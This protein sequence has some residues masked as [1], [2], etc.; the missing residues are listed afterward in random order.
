MYWKFI[1]VHIN[2]VVFQHFATCYRL[3]QD[4]SQGVPSWCEQFLHT[5]L[6]DD[7]IQILPSTLENLAKQPLIVCP[8]EYCI[9]QLT[10]THH[11][12][13]SQEPVG[14]VCSAFK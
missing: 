7:M 2:S 8:P 1:S 5:M 4:R 11:V 3:L 12:A 14:V 6:Y 13:R 9:Q 10:T